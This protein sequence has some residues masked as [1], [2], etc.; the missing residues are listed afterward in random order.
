MTSLHP[1]LGVGLGP[2]QV[3]TDGE[4]RND[5]EERPNV[6]LMAEKADLGKCAERCK[7]LGLLVL[8]LQ[9]REIPYQVPGSLGTPSPTVGRTEVQ[10]GA[11]I[12]LTHPM[13]KNDGELCKKKR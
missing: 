5:E 6:T 3:L 8:N 1:S 7:H 12:T 2:Y 4:E 10:E 11:A 13:T 9:I